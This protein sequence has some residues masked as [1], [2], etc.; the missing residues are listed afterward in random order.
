MRFNTL[1]VLTSS[2]IVARADTN[3]THADFEAIL[4]LDANATGI[5][6]E[7]RQDDYLVSCLVD[8]SDDC[9]WSLSNETA[10]YID[11]TCDDYSNPA[12][13]VCVGISGALAVATH[14]PV[15]AS[16]GR[17]CSPEDIT[18]IGLV[19]MDNLTECADGDIIGG[20]AC[21]ANDVAIS[22]ECN[23]CLT[24]SALGPS[25]VCAEMCNDV[26]LQRQCADCVNANFLI[27]M[28]ACS[29]SSSASGIV[30]ISSIALLM[31]ATVFTM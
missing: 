27:A 18:A 3:C 21:F 4:H 1:I 15:A 31:L 10:D 29:V 6:L 23:L 16:V 20:I 17:A 19:S 26:D 11:G 14:V 28:T 5:C 30:G 2:A 25:T 12:F 8:V 24:V 9:A 13:D 7:G 22:G